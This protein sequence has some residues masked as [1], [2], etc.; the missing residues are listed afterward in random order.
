MSQTVPGLGRYWS[1]WPDARR[2]LRAS[3]RGREEGA[4]D[5]VSGLC[6]LLTGERRRALGRSVPAR[7]DAS[8]RTG[9]CPDRDV[10]GHLPARGGL[11][12]GLQTDIQ[13]PAQEE[14]A[15]RA[16]SSALP[17]SPVPVG[18]PGSGHAFFP[19]P[20]HFRLAPAEGLFPLSHGA[21]A[22]KPLMLG[23]QLRGRQAGGSPTAER[24][25]GHT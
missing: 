17:L 24:S 2:G 22:P 11:R 4:G 21:R 13:I 5:R 25:G 6:G 19:R 14:A 15:E 20:A 12:G 18:F 9:S 3:C 23:A 7:T 10:G 1:G 8:L 16:G